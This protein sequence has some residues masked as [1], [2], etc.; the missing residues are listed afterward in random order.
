VEQ[1]YQFTAVSEKSLT[2]TAFQKRAALLFAALALAALGMKSN[3]ALAVEPGQPCPKVT[4][5]ADGQSFDAAKYSGKVVYVDFWASWCP[6]CRVSLPWLSELQKKYGAEKLQVIAV[7]VDSD[8]ADAKRF[9]AGI[10]GIDVP[11]VFDPEGKLPAAFD[12]LAMPSSYLLD[13]HGKVVSVYQG[14]RDSE[15]TQVE[16]KIQDLLKL[17]RNS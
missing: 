15:K 1:E 8:S 13:Q 7:N 6:S 16:S 3:P 11:V 14:L 12:L 10:S 4:L 17:N 2:V 9:L 5:S